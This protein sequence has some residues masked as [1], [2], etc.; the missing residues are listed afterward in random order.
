MP[1]HNL[2]YGCLERPRTKCG[3]CD[4][5]FKNPW[6]DL[7]NG[8]HTAHYMGDGQRQFYRALYMNYER[9]ERGLVCVECREPVQWKVKKSKY[10]PIK[11]HKEGCTHA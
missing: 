4:E 9:T 7:E 2:C 11:T 6:M 1:E 3:L 5:C 8:M 10:Q